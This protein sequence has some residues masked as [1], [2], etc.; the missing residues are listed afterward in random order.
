MNTNNDQLTWAEVDLRAVKHNLR[1]IKRLTKC[2]SLVL[3]TRPKITAQ[4]KVLAVVKADAY[5]HGMVAVAQA[6]EKDIYYFGVSNSAEAITLRKAGIKKP[7]LLFESTFA[8]LADDIVKYDLTATVCT[9]QLAAAIN[10]H[11]KRAKKI[12]PVHLKIDTG[13]SRLGVSFE[14]AM[15]FI[16][17]VASLKNIY[18]EGIYTHFPSADTNK[19]LTEKQLKLLHQFVQRLDVLAF[20]VPLVHAANS[21]GLA[22]Y[23]TKMV[24]LV[25]PGL[26]IY[27]L[28][29][30]AGIQ[31]L[32][33]KPALQIKSKVIFLKTL[34]KGT[35][36]SYG[37][38]FVAKH[39]MQIAII[40]IGYND[41]YFRSLSNKASVLIAGR[42]CP[43]LG[44]VTMDQ[45]IVDVSR[46]KNVK[47]GSRVTILGKDQKKTITADELAKHAKTINY[48]IVCS[49][50]NRITRSFS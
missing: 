35:G 27:G 13:M 22:G 42:R 33:L 14:E 49:L 31:K 43:I 1:E 3:P 9:H 36:V 17:E 40:P 8:N 6:I 46:V 37:H 50:G 47:L 5:G 10:K 38:R 28:L 15:D 39:R 25:R 11:A 41:G 19:A 32:N 48:E 29:P 24:N 16:R 34:E 44:N 7:I 18:V 2:H 21:M 45:I 26:M 30:S 23:K 20:R 12:A 4:A